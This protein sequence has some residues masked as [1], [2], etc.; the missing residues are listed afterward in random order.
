VN[1]YWKDFIQSL[2]SPESWLKVVI[3]LAAL[4]IW[5]PTLRMMLREFLDSLNMEE[6][7]KIPPGEDPFVSVPFAAHRRPH[8]L[9]PAN[10]K[11]GER[12]PRPRARSGSTPRT[13]PAKKSGFAP[14]RR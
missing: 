4:P 13:G 11:G 5:W 8:Q 7:R 10:R 14:A 9:G 3:M 6:Q 1:D 2:Y 12:T